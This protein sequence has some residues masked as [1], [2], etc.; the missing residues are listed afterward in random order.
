MPLEGSALIPKAPFPSEVNSTAPSPNIVTG[1]QQGCV[2]M[3][4]QFSQSSQSTY[5][6]QLLQATNI[7]V[8]VLDAVAVCLG[9]GGLLLG[10][11]LL[12]SVGYC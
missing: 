1:L 2:S 5:L 11:E 7:N 12:W 10:Q 9:G 4:A 6:F 8:I 3:L